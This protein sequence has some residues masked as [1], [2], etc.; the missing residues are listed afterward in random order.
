MK[1]NQE[2]FV[3]NVQWI[4]D[5]HCNGNASVFNGM[6]RQRDAMTR[7][8]NPGYRPSLLVL[9]EI[10]DNFPVSLDWLITG[11]ESDSK[12]HPCA[13]LE[14]HCPKIKKIILSEHPVITP[15]FLA[16]LAAFDYSIDK[17]K[18]EK[19]LRKDI[20]LLRKQVDKLTAPPTTAKRSADSSGKGGT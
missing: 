5:H 11:N 4:I 17:D 20:A 10:T 3:N 18:D 2:I 1:W 6:V 7:W 15:A 19:K 8:K 12:P 16:N 14:E 13:G 9:L